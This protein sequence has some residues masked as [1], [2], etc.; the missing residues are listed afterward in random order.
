MV[1][2]NNLRPD[3][4]PEALS[5]AHRP[6]G[7]PVDVHC[8]ECGRTYSSELI[9]W[10]AADKDRP[11]GW[12]CPFEPCPGIGFE[13]DLLPADELDVEDPC[14]HCSGDCL[15]CELFGLHCSG[16]DPEATEDFE[17]NYDEDVSFGFGGD[18]TLEDDEWG[19]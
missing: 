2:L 7:Q 3:L 4:P 14:Q 17:C 5:D 10:R 15:Q 12:Y 18:D 16:E 1:M 13:F 11:A 6:P 8:I 9:V 19:L